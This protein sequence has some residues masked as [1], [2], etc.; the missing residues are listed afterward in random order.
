MTDADGGRTLDDLLCAPREALRAS[1]GTAGRL[2][3]EIA[4]R[5]VRLSQLQA[6]LVVRAA[7]DGTREVA[8]DRLLTMEAVAELFAVPVAHAREMGRRHEIPTVR[9]GRYVRVRESSLR[10]WLKQREEVD[11][12]PARAYHPRPKRTAGASARVVP[13]RQPEADR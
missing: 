9:V 5:Q 13:L 10:A 12:A 1:P 3:S 2:L 7:G 4:E 8:A 6:V 11:S